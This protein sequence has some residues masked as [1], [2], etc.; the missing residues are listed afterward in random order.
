MK[1]GLIG[2][3]VAHSKSP[4]IH[5]YWMKQYGV[6]G[7]YNLIDAPPEAL[8]ET[9]KRLID[10]GYDGFN[11]T[12][13]HKEAIL[14]FCD[15]LDE[16][17]KAIGAVN[18]VSIK[19]GRLLG[20]NTDVYGFIQNLKSSGAVKTLQGKTA[21]IL[22]AGGAARAV[23]YGL[24]KEGAKKI[25]L[26]NRTRK[27][28]ENL[29]NEFGTIIEVIDWKNREDQNANIN[30]LVNTTSLGMTGKPKLK[31]SMKDLS[32]NAVVNDIVYTPLE[33][34]LLQNAVT[35]GNQAVTG[36]GMLIYQAAPAFELW[37]GIQPEVNDDLQNLVLS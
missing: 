19:D 7:E 16:G 27:K 6:T 37:T 20:H 18:S 11:V 5:E 4:L 10:E 23:I 15:W 13:P 30:L 24:M 14:P 31:F 2:H 26:C 29:Q 3:P 8:E 35:Q 12:V 22:G 1:A 32:H 28:A 21:L 36:I 9:I 33:T 17:A 25:Y 34:P